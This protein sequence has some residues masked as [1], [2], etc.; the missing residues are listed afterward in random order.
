MQDYEA[1]GGSRQTKTGLPADL[2][3][4]NKKAHGQ[5]FQP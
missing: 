2:P 3:Y 4:A 5:M 1:T